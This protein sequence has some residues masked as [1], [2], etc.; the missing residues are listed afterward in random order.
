VIY[1]PFHDSIGRYSHYVSAVKPNDRCGGYR[2]VASFD[3]Y[4]DR[5]KVGV[6]SPEYI[7][8]SGIRR[9]LE[10]NYGNHEINRA[11]SGSPYLA[12]LLFNAGACAITHDTGYY[13]AQDDFLS[14][15]RSQIG[16]DILDGFDAMM[17]RRNGDTTNWTYLSGHT[18]IDRVMTDADWRQQEKESERQA[19]QAKHARI[20]AAENKKLERIQERRE[21]LK[22]I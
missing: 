5:G 19:Q 15:V 3:T 10:N 18:Q 21:Q 22:R 6:V 1:F 11:E 16:P 4:Y 9:I 13:G 20:V 12:M 8:G 14:A 2:I 17:N 7:I